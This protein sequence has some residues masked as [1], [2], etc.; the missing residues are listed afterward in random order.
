MHAEQHPRQRRRRQQRDRR[1]PGVGDDVRVEHV[2]QPAGEV[3]EAARAPD[4]LVEQAH[5]P[6]GAERQQQRD[7]QPVDQPRGQ[8]ERVAAGEPR[9]HRPQVAA[10]LP[11]EH[12]PQRRLR[13]PRADDVVQERARRHVQ[14]DLRLRHAQPRPLQHR[15]DD[16]E[17]G[18]PERD[19]GFTP[20]QPHAS[21]SLRRL[22]SPPMRAASLLAARGVLVA[23]PVAIAFFAGG[24]FDGPRLVRARRRRGAARGARARRRAAA[25]PSRR[26]PRAGRRAGLRRLDRAVGDVGAGDALRG[27][28]RRARAALR[29][30]ARGRGAGVLHAR[31]GARARAARRRGHGDRHRLRRRR[32]AAA[33]SDRRAPPAERRRSPRPAAD[34]LERHGRARRARASCCAR[35]WP[36]TPSAPARC[37]PPRSPP[38]SRWAPAAT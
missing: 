38:P 4:E 28:R 9:A 12:V 10:V 7:P 14:V 34:L 27:V 18:Q 19:R 35:A 23:G 37:G 16:G 20:Q 33:G 32:P 3:A 2:E 6:P 1:A 8:P 24:F 26:P 30:R 5:H 29:R 22:A 25:R 36:A 17:D 11:G 21:S 13:R 15:R 31:G